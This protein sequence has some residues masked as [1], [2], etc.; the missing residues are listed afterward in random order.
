M[1][2]PASKVSSAAVITWL[3]FVP[4]RVH[5]EGEQRA[6][7]RVKSIIDTILLVEVSTRIIKTQLVTNS[8]SSQNRPRDRDKK[9]VTINNVNH[10]CL[11][12]HWCTNHLVHH[13]PHT[14]PLQVDNSSSNSSSSSWLIA[15]IRCTSRLIMPLLRVLVAVLL[16]VIKDPCPMYQLAHHQ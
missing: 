3:A 15:I 7:R 16:C 1:R 13:M 5:Q 6:Q 9:K 4:Q 14:Q 10:Q 8:S 2:Q 12:C 11:H